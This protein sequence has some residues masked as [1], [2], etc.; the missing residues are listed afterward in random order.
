M[1]NYNFTHDLPLNRCSHAG[2][3]TIKFHYPKLKL[4]NSDLRSHT[5]MSV[6]SHKG[7]FATNLHLSIVFKFNHCS[8]IWIADVCDEAAYKSTQH[9]VDAPWGQSVQ[10]TI[11]M[12]HHNSCK[13]T[14]PQADTLHCKNHDWSLTPRAITTG[15]NGAMNQH[16]S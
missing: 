8:V 10:T 14:P 13:A 16:S 6:P 15:H 12:Q 2:L 3:A 1:Y 4:S 11:H 7:F 9:K 5:V